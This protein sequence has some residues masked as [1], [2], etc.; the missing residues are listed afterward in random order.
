MTE[1]PFDTCPVVIEQKMQL[2]PSLGHLSDGCKSV[3]H[4]AIS[5][6]NEPGIFPHVFYISHSH[7]LCCPSSFT[8]GHQPQEHFLAQRSLKGKM[9]QNAHDKHDNGGSSLLKDAIAGG[10]SDAWRGIRLAQHPE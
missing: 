10:G 6:E 8:Q 4:T 5:P 3:T 7:M 2:N 9:F 1:L